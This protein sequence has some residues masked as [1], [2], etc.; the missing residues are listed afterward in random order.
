MNENRTHECYAFQNSDVN[1][2]ADSSSGGF[3]TAAASSILNQG[4]VVYAAVMTERF[5]VQHIRI[6]HQGQLGDARKSKYLQSK[7]WPVYNRIRED[8]DSHRKVLFVGTPC[9][10]A[11]VKKIA[12]DG[13]LITIDLLCH[14]VANAKIAEKYAEGLEEKQKSRLKKYYFRY[15]PQNERGGGG[16][17]VVSGEF[18]NG[19]TYTASSLKDAYMT[20]FNANLFLRPSCYKCAYAGLNRTGDITIGDFWGLGTSDKTMIKTGK[21]VNFVK[22]NTS[23]GQNLFNEIIGHK[24]GI[25]EK[26]DLKEAIRKNQTLTKPMEY[27]RNRTRFFKHFENESFEDM[28]RRYS[29]QYVRGRKIDRYRQRILKKIKKL[30][31][32]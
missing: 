15:K 20:G 17:V 4:G 25:V 10:V 26:H 14:G 6:S 13:L 21:G 9:Q 8:I 19:R 11:A 30:L 22:I 18:E 23:A 28:I 27:N 12:H 7:A 16:K 24:M 2:L 32:R 31:K 29:R 5:N 3:F 1:I